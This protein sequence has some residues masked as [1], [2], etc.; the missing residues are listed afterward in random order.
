MKSVMRL[1]VTATLLLMWGAAAWAQEA[2]TVR[3]AQIDGTVEIRKG[4]AQSWNP[5]KEGDVLERGD[6]LSAKAKSAAVIHWSNG[7]MAKVYPNTE[8][9]LTGVAFDLE[10]KLEKS[11]LDLTNGRMFVKA[12]VPEH[13]FADFMVRMGKLE[14]RAQAAE[15]AVKYDPNK[16]NFTAWSLFGRLVSQVGTDV[17]RIDGGFQGEVSAGVKPGKN[18]VAAMS[19]EIKNSLTKVSNQLGG[20][21]LLEEETTG[22]A[23][24]K[25]RAKIGGV[26][27]R[28]GNFPYTVNF[29]ALISG[30]SG[31]IKSVEWEFGDGESA[32]TREVEHTFTQGLYIVVLRVED[33][34]GEKASAQIGIS[35][36]EECS[37]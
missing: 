3:I 31:K 34:G 23:G 30:G 5:A 26:T 7:S 8:F 29:K 25:L 2:S 12:Q 13:L 33:E 15:F 18:D 9:V 28:R 16:K 14:L 22:S 21:L 32:T 19:G 24:G 11:I 37:C 27:N 1:A 17:V 10:K 36:E 20:S 35:V 4:D 6:R